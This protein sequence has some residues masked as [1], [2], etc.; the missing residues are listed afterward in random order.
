MP[1]YITEI[2]RAAVSE[3][4]PLPLFL[5]PVEAGF[6]SPAE[7][8]IEDQLDLSQHL[9]KRPNATYFARVVGD[10]MIEAGIHSGDLLVIDRALEATDGKIVIAAVN[11]ELTVKR[12]RIRGKQWFLIPENPNYPEILVTE[13]MDFH[14]W[15]V[16]TNVVHKV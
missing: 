7:A 16:V 2:Y 11:G 13:A 12:L 15:G 4:M 8:Y 14:I 1:T 6:P 9:V 5:C 10:S 3:P